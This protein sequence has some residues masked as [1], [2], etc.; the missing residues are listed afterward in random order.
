MKKN[1]ILLLAL[2]IVAFVAWY[3]YQNS[4]PGTIK[5]EPL[6]NFAI[7]DTASINKIIIT[8]QDGNVAKLVRIPGNKLWQLNDQYP[9]REDAVNLL[10][11][12]F[13]RMRIRGNVSDNARENMMKLMVTNS[14][15]VEVF[16]GGDE[17]AKIYYVG[18]PTPDHTGT[19]MLLEIPG[20]GRSEEPYITHMEGFSGFLSTRFFTDP[21]E[22][23][24]TGVFSYPELEFHTVSIENFLDPSSS[25]AVEYRGGNDIKLY[26]NYQAATKTFGNPIPDFDTLAIKNFL[27]MFKKMHVESYNTGLLPAMQDSIR[28]LPP[29]FRISVIGNNNE[30]NTIDLYRRKSTK[31]FIDE[32][33]NPILWDDGHFWGIVNH[34]DLALAQTYTFNPVLQPRIYYLPKK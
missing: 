25:I 17:P 15:R 30:T 27:L 7:E 19:H 21:Y 11:E 9:A 3:F 2:L 18:I 12:T 22:W 13:K 5:D 16:M 29:S 33:G 6:S 23:R 26:E 20:I 4:K 34:G 14:K 1:L 28:N 8:D 32:A 24:Y 31:N 10:L